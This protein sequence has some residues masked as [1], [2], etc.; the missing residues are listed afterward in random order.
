MS[1][2]RRVIFALVCGL[3][4]SRAQW[5]MT[6]A[7]SPS[8]RAIA[9]DVH[10]V[11][12]DAAFVNVE[13]AGLSLHSFGALEANQYDP[14]AGPR[15]L[16][17]RLPRYP[18]KA[19]NPVSAPLGIIGVFVT[20]VPIYNPIGTNSYRNQNIWH[21]D[22][23]AAAA[24][25]LGE[26]PLVSNLEKPNGRNSPVIGYALDGFPIYGPFGGPFAADGQRMKSSYRLR[27]IAKRNTLP[28]GTV[29]TPGQEGPDVGPDFRLGYFAEDY[30][31]VAASGDLD[32]FNGSS[33]DGTY[34]YFMTETWPY[35]IGPR[36]YG[37][38]P[39]QTPARLRWQHTDNVDLWT[40]RAQ[41]LAGEPVNLTF[42]FH[43]AKGRA[44]RFLEKIHEQPVHLIVVSKDLADFDH[45]H[46]V[47]VPGDALSVA[48][49]FRRAGDYWLYADYTAPGEP[50]S[51]TRFALTV[52]GEAGKT[53]EPPSDP[54][55]H[56]SFERPARI[57]AGEDVPLAFTLTNTGTGQPIAD[58]QPWLGAWAHIMIVSADGKTFIHAHP[59]EG[60]AATNPL[61]LHTH[62]A[63]VAGPSPA[64]IR[65]VTG[66]RAPGDYKLWLQFQRKGKIETF[67]W[68]LKVSAGRQPA[69]KKTALPA[70][71]IPVTISRA[72]FVPARVEIPADK[73]AHL[74][75]QRLDAQNCA[76]EVV[77]PT[78]GIRKPLPVGET[79]MVDLP[80][81][82]A[83]Q[84]TFACGM[85][86]Y[87][88]AVVIQ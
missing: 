76:S 82:P 66:F 45:I 53:S 84:M 63:L 13:S 15:T 78:L 59:L 4:V 43:D 24:A 50:P 29:L 62:T 22:A 68:N 81:Q 46:P 80:A 32:E 10:S 42:A 5:V 70:G 85:G 25:V 8:V 37:E 2:M 27:P 26:S 21:Q 19:A 18:Q 34:R 6:T 74:A 7:T 64:T 52:G 31:Y 65:T 44:I 57:Q 51:I 11:T 86:M 55:I 38:A 56:I 88:G 28:D 75:F 14:P 40:D 67:S 87:K 33:A 61:T 60:A 9:P 36:Y 69:P 54:S 47:P 71:A 16:N 12:S 3:S 17:F 23:V 72:G 35:L 41:I 49:T 83:G 1:A 77:F 20:G 58:L 73:P 48:H 39:L 79:V 30:E